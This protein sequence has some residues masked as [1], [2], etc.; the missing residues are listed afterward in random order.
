MFSIR[1]KTV[2]HTEHISKSKGFII[3]DST[4]RWKLK[5][6]ISR[7]VAIVP[8]QQSALYDLRRRTQLTVR[9]TNN[10]SGIEASMTLPSALA[11]RDTHC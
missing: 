1:Y 9:K 6:P 4:A 5:A 7:R 11:R 2:L 10:T 8:K 3:N